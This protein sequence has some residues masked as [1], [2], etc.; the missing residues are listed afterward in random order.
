MLKD[1]KLAMTSLAKAL[2]L[3]VSSLQG[4]PRDLAGGLAARFVSA[5]NKWNDHVDGT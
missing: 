3:T 2:D 1:W 5:W 4:R